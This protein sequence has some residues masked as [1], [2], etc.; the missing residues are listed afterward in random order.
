[1]RYVGSVSIWYLLFAVLCGSKAFAQIR[2]TETGGGTDYIGLKAPSSVPSN[3]TW[4]LP[5]ADGSSNQCLATNGSGSLFWLTPGSAVWSQNGSA[6]YYNS[7]RVGI[8]TSLPSAEADLQ[9]LDTSGYPIIKTGSWGYQG[10]GMS[11]YPYFGTTL[12]FDGTNWVSNHPTVRGTI[13]RMTSNKINLSSAPPNSNPATVTDHLTVDTT[14]GNVGIGTTIPVVALDVAGGLRAG[15]S[16][17]VTACGSGAAAG[18]GTQ[19]YNYTTHSMEFCNGATWVST[20]ATMQYQVFTGSG[21]FT[22]PPGT[23]SATQF[24]F[25]IVGG[26]GGGGNYNAAEDAVATA[27]NGT[28]N[29]TGGRGSFAFGAGGS[30]LLGV[31]GPVGVNNTAG[32]AGSGYGAG[33]G[34]GAMTNR[35]GGVGAPGIVIVEW[36]Q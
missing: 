27:T 11:G 13:L 21:T 32:T 30:S 31:G 8:G 33:G 7:G 14:T 1:M 22:T 17:A 16:A 20:A 2:F 23:N 12:Y 18:E 15:S 34:G 10:L 28:I 35:A 5:D 19:R 29:M 4:T 24:K 25:T 9:V 36:V 26:G 3:F 6:A